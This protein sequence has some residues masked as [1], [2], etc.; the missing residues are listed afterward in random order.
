M[1]MS[2]S[3]CQSLDEFFSRRVVARE[4]RSY[5]RRGPIRSTQKLIQA[6]LAEGVETCTLLDIG[7]G[8]GAIQHALFEAGL[9]FAVS[10]DAS[11][12]YMR[13]A[14][15]E[16]LR[17]GNRT[18]TSMY[19][20]DF[21]ELASK[22]K[23]ADIVTLDRVLCCYKEADKLVA[24]SVAKARCLYGLVYPRNSLLARGSIVL[25]NV[26]CWLSR[27]KFRNYYHHHT[28]IHDLITAAGLSRV[29][30]TKTLVWHIVVYRRGDCA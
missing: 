28:N 30:S 29:Y 9:I 7:A 1:T 11:I 14:Q 8:I 13:A 12:E 26:L 6:L 21:V 5:R 27:K 23:D 4:L 18:H 10:V 3:C 22:I 24:A 15:Q 20:G 17:L 19:Y 16:T 2:S 25:F